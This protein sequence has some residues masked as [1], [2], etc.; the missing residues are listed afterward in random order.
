MQKGVHYDLIFFVT[1]RENTVRFICALVV[2][3]DL[4]RAAFDITKSYCWADRLPDKLLALMHPN[5]FQEYDLVTGEELF[6][7]LRKNLYGD[8]AVGQLFG[9]AGDKVIMEK[10]NCDGW[11]CWRCK[12]DPCLFVIQRD[13]K[14][15]WVLAHVDDC[16]I[17]GEGQDFCENVKAVCATIWK[18]TDVNPECCKSFY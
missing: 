14:R 17:A 16:D 12:M 6:I 7:I 2:L 9:K 10:F 13:G 15:A 18:I 5:G 4:S 11:T 8:P 3:L 1:P